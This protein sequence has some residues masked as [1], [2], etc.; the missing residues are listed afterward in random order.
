MYSKNDNVQ[1]RREKTTRK[2]AQENMS[3]P[4]NIQSDKIKKPAKTEEEEEKSLVST[5][6]IAKTL[7]LT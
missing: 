4:K 1:D 5:R 3:P 2:S 7:P 6:H